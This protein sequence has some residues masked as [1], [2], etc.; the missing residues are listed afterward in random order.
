MPDLVVCHN[1]GHL[2]SRAGME[3]KESPVIAFAETRRQLL[4]I[5]VGS[6]AT[7]LSLPILIDA[8]SQATSHAAHMQARETPSV[9][10]VLKYFSKQ[11]AQTLDALCEVMIPADDHSPGA[12]AAK[13][14]QYIDEIVSSA[15]DT[16]KLWVAGLA[17]IDRMARDQ[18]AHAYAQC[19]ADQQEA[20]MEKIS[21]S[22]DQPA[23][24][25]EKFFV[26]LKAATIDGYYT[27]KISIH[28]DLSYQPNTLVLDFQGCTHDEHKIG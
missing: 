19:T 8:A 26:A 1:S 18:Y 15:A 4:K 5:V 14:S 23:A 3:K 2:Q 22:E 10:Y 13:V 11:Q 25:E 27:S 6:A 20:L 9:P 16:R 21:R 28:P 12:K 7:T 24:L 17:A